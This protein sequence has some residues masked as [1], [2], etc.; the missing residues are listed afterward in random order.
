MVTYLPG[1]LIAYKCCKPYKM[2]K[3]MSESVRKRKTGIWINFT[4]DVKEWTRIVEGTGNFV[5]HLHVFCQF[6]QSKNIFL[7][8]LNTKIKHLFV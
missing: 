8:Y 6:K 4:F 2:F 3:N 1:G 7:N 5:M